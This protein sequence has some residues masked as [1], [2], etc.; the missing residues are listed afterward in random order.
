MNIILGEDQALP[1][2]EKY[3]V[4][5]LD[6]FNIANHPRPIKS[7]CVIENM[8]IAEM[9]ECHSYRDL[10]EN[11]IINYGRRNWT[12]CEQAIGHLM[13]RWNR[14]LD[15]FYT[16]LLARVQQYKQQEPSEDW[17]PILNR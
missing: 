8:P 17:T 10:H 1:L 11:L 14:E 4:L 12:Y 7:F 15:S 3:T 13:G 6:S 5:S 16:D 2:A 9:A